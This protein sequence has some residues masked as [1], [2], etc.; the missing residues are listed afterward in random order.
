MFFKKL[1]YNS[2]VVLSFALLSLAALV[3]GHLT[4]QASN[5]LL[6]SI[7]RAPL[8][9]PLLYLRIFLHVLGH[10]DLEHYMSNMLL[11]L[12]IGPALED[13]YKSRGMLLAM[14][15]TAAVTGAAQLLF[16]PSTALMGASGIVFMMII[17]SSLSGMKNG[18]I[19]VTLLVVAAFYLGR[20][21]ADAMAAPDGISHFTHLLGGVCGGVFGGVW[22]LRKTRRRQAA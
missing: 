7:Y 11:L 19:P 6:F 16:F 13:K 15:C 17:L 10:A 22:P 4:G 3:L 20:E 5:T 21:L 8:S 14:G 12:V 2:P 1:Q 9:D 18:R